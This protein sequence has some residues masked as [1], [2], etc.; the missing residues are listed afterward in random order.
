MAGR[1]GSS[2]P[3]PGFTTKD[4]TLM[5]LLSC[6]IDNFGKL[7]GL[8]YPFDE[9][10]CVLFAEN[11]WGKSTLAAFLRVMFYGFEGENR[12]NEDSNERM[13]YRPWQGGVYGGSVTFRCE[14]RTY[15][16]LRVFGDRKKDDA[17]RLYDAETG[18]PD[19][20]YSDLIGEELFGIDRDSF[21]RTVFW[22][23]Q[24]H[25]TAATTAIQAKIGDLSA[26]SD[27]LPNYDLA[28]RQLR[29]EMERLRP[30]R[31]SGLIKKKEERLR[32]LE[33]DEVRLPLLQTQLLR[34][35]EEEAELTAELD[36]IRKDRQQCALAFSPENA[37]S[38]GRGGV[39]GDGA[40][41]DGAGG[42]VTKRRETSIGTSTDA[43]K[44]RET[45]LQILR[46]RLE[47]SASRI[48]ML[49]RIRRSTVRR[50]QRE[51]QELMRIRRA[52]KAEARA[53]SEHRSR[54]AFRLRTAA[55]VCA[56]LA[57]IL[58]LTYF[59]KLLPLPALIAA[60]LSAAAGI[61]AG[62]M[63]RNPEAGIFDAPSGSGLQDEEERQ[64]ARLRSLS[65]NLHTAQEQ[66]EDE[67][68]HYRELR[69]EISRM[70]QASRLEISSEEQALRI[71]PAPPSVPEEISAKLSDYDVKE[72]NC[73]IHLQD[74]RVQSDELRSEIRACEE[75][76]EQLSALR[77][78][79]RDLR[80]RF[81][82]CEAT[83]HYLEQARNS[84][85]SRYM[86]PFLRSFGRYYSML[87][88]ES[89]EALQT[90]ADF[91]IKVMSGGLPRDPSLMSEGTKDL[92]NLCRRMAMIDAMYPGEKPFLVLDDPFANLDDERVKGGLRFL[93]SA[94]LDYQILYLTCHESRL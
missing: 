44:A 40:G 38:A 69:S 86:N 8:D 34:Q 39:S 13:R 47:A 64:C 26:G 72:E 46:T 42:D 32:A 59:A 84:F 48:R 61:A 55:A 17:F 53:Q 56:C 15:K 23:Q 54:I 51:K 71:A 16:M 36:R 90:D 4:I 82:T 28:V 73:R 85:T 52:Q 79:I 2:V 45:E 60:L 89:A 35:T 76:K 65:R 80:E 5:K 49:D 33:A 37:A 91:S 78:E 87:T 41:R 12:R 58:L 21:R 43:I 67:Q 77:D 27:D 83:L 94:S 88:G 18:L 93:R 68:R 24:D 25:E 70:E 74:L 9:N 29:K 75:S 14:G 10:L 31:A 62:C 22:S 81:D 7:S 20:T 11:G 1:A 6:H 50:G 92:I 66:I 57:L 30:D 19:S 3:D 63:S